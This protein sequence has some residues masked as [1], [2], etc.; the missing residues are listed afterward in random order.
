MFPFELSFYYYYY[1]FWNISMWSAMKSVS[2]SFQSLT[3]WFLGVPLSYLSIIVL[4]YS[5][6]ICYE[7]CKFPV[8]DTMISN[9][10]MSYLSI[11]I[12]SVLVYS[13]VI[14]NEGCKFPVI[15]TLISSFP[16]SYLS[17]LLSLFCNIPLWSAMKSV[18]FQ[19][20]TQWFHSLWVIFPLIVSVLKYSTMICLVCKFPVIDT[21]I[22]F[23]LSYLSINYLCF[24][25]FHHDLLSL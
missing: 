14:C 7:A 1:L 18:S 9:F 8:I 25:I 17:L 5:T 21:L 12:I 2:V 16:M 19:S 10:P 4:I 15:D 24:E 11:I 3:H 23:S 20:L 6:V 13:T 22:S